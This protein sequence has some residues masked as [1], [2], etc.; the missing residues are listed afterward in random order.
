MKQKWLPIE[1]EA[2][3][4]SEGEEIRVE[5]KS[6]K[7]KAETMWKK[8]ARSY[9]VEWYNK[10]TEVKKLGQKYFGSGREKENRAQE[11]VERFEQRVQRD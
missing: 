11:K 6:E 8:K 2:N 1:E 3:M 9:I 10:G 4:K 5:E 7:Y